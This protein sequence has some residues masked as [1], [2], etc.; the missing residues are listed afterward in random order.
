MEEWKS[1]YEK[2]FTRKDTIHSPVPSFA[3]PKELIQSNPSFFAWD[4]KSRDDIDGKPYAL[5]L[6]YTLLIALM[7]VSSELWSK[8]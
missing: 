7:L 4:F 5:R 8:E 6:Y 3:R 2:Q 1:E